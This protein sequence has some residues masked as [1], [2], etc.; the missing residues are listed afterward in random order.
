MV[1]VQEAASLQREVETVSEERLLQE[2]IHGEQGVVDA[3]GGIVATRLTV[4]VET[5]SPVV[6]QD[7]EVVPD[8]VADRSVEFHLA[9]V[10]TYAL[11]ILQRH[12]HSPRRVPNLEERRLS[13]HLESVAMEG[14]HV[15][16][17]DERHKLVIV[18]VTGVL[19]GD[20]IHDAAID[21]LSP[22]PFPRRSQR[23]VVT[24]G[25]LQLRVAT[26]IRVAVDVNDIVGEI[27]KRRTGDVDAIVGTQLR[28]PHRQAQSER[29]EP[30]GIVSVHR[31]LALLEEVAQ[32]VLVSQSCLQTQLIPEHAAIL[33]E[34][35][36]YLLL[37]LGV[38]ILGGRI[39][40]QFRAMRVAILA[41]EAKGSAQEWML[42]DQLRRI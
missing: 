19:K 25:R 16:G 18:R 3:I 4:E 34:S 40:V 28:L 24:V 37:H 5:H 9:A 20:V 14:W 13:E 23:E 22:N 29:R 15:V 38:T 17:M 36:P 30:V 26:L 10:G 42:D 21:G 33:H 35:A 27:G 7:E 11:V 41:S 12:N 2:G 31:V 6:R 39:D 1:R 8:E 32:H